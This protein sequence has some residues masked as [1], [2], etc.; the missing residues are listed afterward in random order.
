MSAAKVTVRKSQGAMH[1]YDVFRGDTHLG[2]VYPRETTKTGFKRGYCV[3]QVP[4]TG[5]FFRAARP[6]GLAPEEGRTDHGPRWRTRKAAVFAL[7][8]VST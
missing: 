3:G 5:W 4:V 1:A 6:E 2:I 8:E 7:S